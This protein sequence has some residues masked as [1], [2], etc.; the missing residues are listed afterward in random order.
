MGL[1]GGVD[2]N[3]LPKSIKSL[4][5]FFFAGFDVLGDEAAEACKPST[6]SWIERLFVAVGVLVG[7]CRSEESLRVGGFG[8]ELKSDVDGR[9][10]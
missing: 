9:R 4:L 3:G 6:M 5:E 1:D 7:V 10:K 8:V 2:V